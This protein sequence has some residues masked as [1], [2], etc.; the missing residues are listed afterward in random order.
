MSGLEFVFAVIWG[1]YCD[2]YVCV[3]NISN[4]AQR[5][6]KEKAIKKNSPTTMKEQLWN[7]TQDGAR[8][9]VY[10]AT[11]RLACPKPS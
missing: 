9:I 1:K 4:F 3:T 5:T 8:S 11:A 6:N 2:I 7:W 10:S